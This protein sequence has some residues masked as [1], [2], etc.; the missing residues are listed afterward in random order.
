MSSSY[1]RN[2]DRLRSAERSNTQ[3]AMSQR[4]EAANRAGNRAI[5]EANKIG[6]QLEA[7]SGTLR[8]MRQED[9]KKRK[10]RGRLAAIEQ[11]NVKSEKL[12]EL[13]QELSTLTATD[14]RYHEIKAEMLKMS[15]P[16]IYP[17]ADRIAHLSPWEQVGYAKEKLRVFNE[18][19]PDKL[20][21]A[22]ANSEKAVKIQN[23]SFT[24]KELHDNNIHGLPFKEA[25]LNIV[26][27]DIKKNAG[28]EKFSPELLE[29]AGVNDAIQKAK[30]STTAKYR[31]RYNVEASSNTRSKAEMSWRTSNKTGEDIYHYLVKTGA[32]MDANNVQVG[33]AGAWKALE[34]LIV[35][36]GINQSDPEYAEQ[37]LNQPMPPALTKKL[38][39]KLGTTY[40]QQ[41][42]SK[43]ATLKQQIKD[44]YTKKIDNDLKNLE[45]AGKGVEVEF[46]EKARTQPLSTQEVNEYKRK[47][48]ELGLT[49][50]S[51]VTN[52][53]TLTMRD[54]RE[55]TQEIEALMASQNGYISNDQLDQF[56]PQAAV[57]FRDKASKLEK[58]QIEQFGGDKQISAALNTV[59]DGMGLKG[60]EKTLEYEIAL[61][62]AKQD[63]NEKFNQYIAMGY[64]PRQ[65]N[66]YAL[67]ADAVKD[68]ET[69][70][71]IPDSQ[72]VI[73]H[74]R[75]TESTNKY[76]S[77]VYAI[78]GDQKQ[79]H[80]R[81]AEIAKGKKQLMN[82]SN[83]IFEEPIGGAYG[84]KQLDSIIN[85]INKY[86]HNKG[87][88]K[89]KGAVKYYQ[90][91]ARGRNINWMGLVDAQLKTTGHKGLF[92]DGRPQLLNLMDGKDS[93]GKVFADPHHFRP[94]IKAVERADKY[95]SRQNMIYAH[96]L[97]Q[98]CF[99]QPITTTGGIVRRPNSI[100]D[101]LEE[102]Y[103]WLEM[104]RL[105]EPLG[106]PDPQSNLPDFI[107]T[108]RKD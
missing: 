38:G 49:I 102:Q 98:D 53:E 72:G 93:D 9:I 48:G 97:L 99:P 11:A 100:W 46:I 37:I 55:D 39:A 27:D 20:N 108:T 45:A 4:T 5:N 19:F 78:Q 89:D 57:E 52:Y 86:G 105:P 33:N 81:V 61:A 80:I 92:P 79:G 14:T 84:K 54:Q 15:G 107:T 62:N 66:H 59:F 51:S 28:L 21:H 16:D 75:Q 41:W 50:P 73:A 43:A 13:E 2:I 36:E 69:G 96:K 56:H 77:P 106:G 87:V 22:M 103:P 76:T 71:L 40:A 101:D 23:M 91:L 8:E 85:N 94:V 83:I 7:F 1:N 65:A 31:Q 44:G 88:L 64:D 10:E 42:P 35:Q 82:N 29:L 30:E 17:D 34:G 104:F 67:N 58:A 3:T 74:I 47:F 68:K 60:N 63:Y 32:T 18:P 90:G 25:A 12:V 24:P 70:E 26:A 95:P 6:E